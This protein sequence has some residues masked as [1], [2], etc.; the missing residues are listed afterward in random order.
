[1]QCG[2][3]VDMHSGLLVEAR[4]RIAYR[5]IATVS[6]SSMD[7]PVLVKESGESVEIYHDGDN[8]FENPFFRDYEGKM[9]EVRGEIDRTGMFY[10][11]EIE[12]VDE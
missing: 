2:L 7:I 11:D 1:M 3:L 5:N 9:V 12:V 6:K 8:P 4:G 10:I